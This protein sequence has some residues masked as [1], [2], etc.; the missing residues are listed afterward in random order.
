MPHALVF[1]QE[2]VYD[3]EQTYPY[4]LDNTFLAP[5]E[6]VYGA[7]LKDIYGRESFVSVTSNGELRVL[8]VGSSSGWV[9]SQIDPLLFGSTRQAASY[10]VMEN[11]LLLSGGHDGNTCSINN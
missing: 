5:G 7:T 6:Q 10:T 11:K 9:V 8:P 2:T 4:Q 1:G 3:L